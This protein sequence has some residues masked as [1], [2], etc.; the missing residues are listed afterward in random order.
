MRTYTLNIENKDYEVEVKSFSLQHA[1]LVVNGKTI[2][3]DVKDVTTKATALSQSE[4]SPA[5]VRAPAPSSA[6]AAPRVANGPGPA[7]AGG[8]GVKA[9]IPGAILSVDVAEGD[10][11]QAGQLL[12]K[13]EAMKMENQIKA[14]R[15]GKV[16]KILVKVGDAVAQGADLL[17]IE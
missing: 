16:T 4:S 11:V 1:T 9:P 3:V 2:H 12:L 13:M 6:P 7:P 8:N 15:A 10:T 5:P 14:P 17:L